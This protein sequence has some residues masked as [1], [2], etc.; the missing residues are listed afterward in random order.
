MEKEIK[1][2]KG[3]AKIISDKCVNSVW[4]ARFLAGDR[5]YCQCSFGDCK[6][7]VSIEY[8]GHPARDYI[9]TENEIKNLAPHH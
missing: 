1:L 4:P 9:L 8:N 7:V 6:V 2:D 3:T 5:E